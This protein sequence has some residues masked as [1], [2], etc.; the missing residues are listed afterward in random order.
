VEE[1]TD[2]EFQEI[3][4]KP[5]MNRAISGKKPEQNILLNPGDL[6]VVP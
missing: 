1:L 5:A 2:V 6:I 3:G 4:E